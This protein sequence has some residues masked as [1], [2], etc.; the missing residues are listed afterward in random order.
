MIALC[1]TGADGYTRGVFVAGFINRGMAFNLDVVAGAIRTRLLDHPTDP[2]CF[3]SE[4]HWHLGWRFARFTGCWPMLRLY[5][6]VFG[7]NFDSWIG[8]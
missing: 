5:G 1:R 8:V 2:I 6:R 4:A 7:R 3:V